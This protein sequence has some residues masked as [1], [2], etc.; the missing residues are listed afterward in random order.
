MAGCFLFYCIVLVYVFA[1]VFPPP[2]LPPYPRASRGG[3]E[4]EH[5]VKH[6]GKLVLLDKLLPRLKEQGHRVLL[7]SQF[8]VCHATLATRHSQRLPFF[9]FFQSIC[10]CDM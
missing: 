7:F 3:N 9:F 8:K 5:L 10:V 6:S 2:V 4:Q 1:V